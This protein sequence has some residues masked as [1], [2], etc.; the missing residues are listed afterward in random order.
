MLTEKPQSRK[1]YEEDNI[2]V[3]NISLNERSAGGDYEDSAFWDVTPCNLA[4]NFLL[5][6]REDAGTMVT[7]N[8]YKTARRHIPQDGVI[9]VYAT[10]YALE[11]W[12]FVITVM[13]LLKQCSNQLLM[14]EINFGR[15]TL[16]TYITA[17]FAAYFNKYWHTK[18][19]A[20][21]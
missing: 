5:L 17:Q 2:K 9:F 18:K 6:N 19:F 3:N 12:T 14:S 10:W 15:N 1:I 4:D 16:W 21:N 20:T 13:S 8:T 7:A 11:W